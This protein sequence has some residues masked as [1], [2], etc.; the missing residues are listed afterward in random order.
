MPDSLYDTDVL[1]WSEHQADLLRR[2]AKGERLAET[3][4]WENVIEEVEALVAQ[5]AAAA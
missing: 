4:D 2:L 5:I 3:I 1:V